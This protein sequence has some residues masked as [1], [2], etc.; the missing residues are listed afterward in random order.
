MEKL[1]GLIGLKGTGKDFLANLAFKN[2]SR[3]A[4]ADWVKYESAMQENYLE[5]DDRIVK[6]DEVIRWKVI[7]LGFDLALLKDKHE[8]SETEII[9]KIEI[10]KQLPEL[11]TR[12]ALYDYFNVEKEGGY[13]HVMNL[14]TKKIDERRKNFSQD[15]VVTDVRTLFEAIEIVSRNGF[16]LN[17]Y[18]SRTETLI[19]TVEFFHFSEYELS[20]KID[21]ARMGYPIDITSR[22]SLYLKKTCEEIIGLFYKDFE[23]YSKRFHKNIQ[24]LREEI[25]E[26]I[27]VYEK[28]MAEAYKKKSFEAYRLAKQEIDKYR[29]NFQELLMNEYKK[30][31]IF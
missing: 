8:C 6:K 25:L 26:E 27:D 1:V 7:G 22:D 2:Y 12:Q 30:H 16:L 28:Q 31:I 19:N 9:K 4:I 5:K 14:T 24:N 20:N 3:L 10:Y 17:V 15:I 23:G 29:R 13:A 21:G 18:N 11:N